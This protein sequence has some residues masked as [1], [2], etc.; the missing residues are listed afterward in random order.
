MDALTFPHWQTVS[1]NMR[2][3]MHT[4]GQQEITKSF[5]LAGGTAIALQLGHRRSYD[6]DFF[7][8]K[9][10]V[11][12]RTAQA[13]QAAL[14]NYN[15]QVIEKTFGNMVLLANKVRTGFFSYGYPLIQE[16]VEL[17]NI[18]LASIADIG[19]MK[20]DALVTRGSRKDFY[21]LF[22]ISRHLPFSSLLDFSEKKYTGFRDFPLQV[23][24]AM[25][26]FDNADR[27]FQPELIEEIS[28]ETVK[29]WFI[30]QAKE[31]GK[32]WFGK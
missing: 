17:E 28:W 10:A 14:N 11:N 15:P 19:L 20:C 29:Q 25:T 4:L 27:D 26:L 2:Q 6:F 16:P 7:S 5:Y 13:I 18:K 21:D 8:E 9:D 22:F 30:E 32:I 1:S 24:E 23:L 12:E 31:L 3:L